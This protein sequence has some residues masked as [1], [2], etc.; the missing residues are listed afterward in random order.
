MYRVPMLSVA[1]AVALTALLLA[2][3]AGA[4]DYSV[5][6]LPTDKCEFREVIARLQARSIEKAGVRAREIQ[7]ILDE[8]R[9][10]S[11]KA[12]T[13]NKPI[14][15]QPSLQESE[16]FSRLSQR[17]LM[18]ELLQMVE[19]RHQRDAGLLRDWAQQIDTFARW[20]TEP[21]SGTED[22]RKWASFMV[23]RLS[24]G[25]AFEIT[26]PK[27]DRCS[28]QLAIHAIESYYIRQFNAL[29]MDESN[30]QLRAL[31]NK[32]GPPPQGQRLDPKTFSPQD[33]RT[34][35]TLLADTVG[36][37]QTLGEQISQYETL[38][39]MA[40]ASDLI[41]SSDSDDIVQTA[42]DANAIGRTISAM[43]ANKKVSERMTIALAMWRKI[44]DQ[45]P[46][47]MAKFY[48]EFQKRLQDAQNTTT[49]K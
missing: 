39:L 14:G 38:K 8:Q 42:G 23:I 24:N 49:K 2:R 43:V 40:T 27:N 6:S 4:E 5:E 3:A 33:Q 18:L 44:D 17:L 26:I 25:E 30:A 22:Y 7:P 31:L 1:F 21:K 12:K 11:D 16:Q 19:S 47:E 10:I 20:S 48:I 29:P 41:Y 9:R 32:Y 15:E 13:P 45:F 46:S 28:I 34:Y 35:N 36:P 37:A